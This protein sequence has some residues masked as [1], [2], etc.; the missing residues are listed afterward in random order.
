MEA[1]KDCEIE[2]WSVMG[3]SEMER[4]LSFVGERKGIERQHNSVVLGGHGGKQ[5]GK[6]KDTGKG[7]N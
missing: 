2:R 6:D 3:V 1:E 4:I 5:R 7:S